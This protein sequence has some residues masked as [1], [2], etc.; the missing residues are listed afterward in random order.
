MQNHSTQ[1]TN[2]LPTVHVGYDHRHTEMYDLCCRSLKRHTEN[3][4]H[5]YA[6]CGSHIPGYNRAAAENEST[7]FVYSRFL[8]PYLQ[9]YR[10]W[11]AFCDGDFLWQDDIR[12]LFAAADDQYAVMVCQHD[13]VPKPNP[14]AFG[15]VQ[16]PFPRKNWSSLILWNCAH[17]ANRLLTLDYINFAQPW[18][19][20]RFVHLQDSMIGSIDLRWNWL[21]DEYAYTETAGALHYT[22]GGPWCGIATGQDKQYYEY[23]KQL[24]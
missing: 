8:V 5:I 9:G 18:Q 2:I 20:H 3:N 6:N 11:A 19:L 24:G 17:P 23:K 7:S 4:V 10:G 16:E 21:V 22:N 14:K 1:L 13:Y 12:K 15:H